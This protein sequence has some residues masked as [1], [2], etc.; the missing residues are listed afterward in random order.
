M[1]ARVKPNDISTT[2]HTVSLFKNLSAQE[3]ERADLTVHELAELFRETTAPSKGALPLFNGT[4]FGNRRS[5]SGSLRSVENAQQVYLI[6]VDYD[7]EKITFDEAVATMQKA[8]VRCILYTSASYVPGAKERWRIV[9]PLSVP[10][11]PD[12]REGLVARVNGLFNGKLAEE[13]FT[14]SLSYYYGSV[15]NNP[16]HRLEVIDGDLLDVRSDLYAGSI[17][18]DGSRVGEKAAKDKKRQERRERQQERQHSGNYEKASSERCHA[19]GQ[20]GIAKL[21]RRLAETPEGQGRN[22]TAVT[23]AFLAGCLVKGGCL[24]E[25]EALDRLTAAAQTW[26]IPDTDR[27]FGPQGA[28]ARGIRA[29]IEKGDP[30][31]PTDDAAWIFDNPGVDPEPQ[32]TGVSLAEAEPLLRTA[33]ERLMND[34]VEWHSSPFGTLLGQPPHSGVKITVGSGKSHVVREMIADFVK[35]CKELRKPHRVLFLVPTH[36]LGR[37]VVDKMPDGVTAALWQ[38]RTSNSAVTGEPMCLNPEAVKVAIDIGA[39]VQKTACR[40]RFPAAIP[41]KVYEC[42]FYKRCGFQAQKKPAKDADVIVAAHQIGQ[43]PLELPG[44]EFGL[45]IID[46]AFWSIMVQELGIDNLDLELKDFPVRDYKSKNNTTLENETGHLRCLLESLMKALKGLPDGYV[47]KSAP[48]AAGLRP[49]ADDD[50]DD[51]GSC[52]IAARYEW[53]RRVGSGLLPGEYRPD[54]LSMIRERFA[55][56]KQIPLRVA[57]W[58][59]LGDLL[60]G[61]AEKSGRLKIVTKT[62]GNGSFRFLR[63]QRPNHFHDDVMRLPIIHLDATMEPDIVRYFLPRLK[64]ELDLDIEA[65]HMKVTQVVGLFR[66]QGSQSRERDWS[67][68]HPADG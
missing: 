34:A 66:H 1:N 25:T 48:L 67:Q 37:E 11:Q 19:Y 51:E 44:G 38:G 35:K 40:K 57:M 30:A 22:K 58:H 47:T 23:V 59:E 60:S 31:G 52:T 15:N 9:L 46:E 7:A 27:V 50:D 41:P 18:K 54:V 14:L 4:I 62:K 20:A 64:M 55:F 5:K 21:E 36:K 29:G 10:Y 16:N 6:E 45:V 13:S 42:P 53:A 32:V 28:I 2:R 39:D 17:F 56:Q 65:P 68:E 63:I 49:T 61:D 24:S 26:G 8:G 12:K 3:I 43:H 33:I